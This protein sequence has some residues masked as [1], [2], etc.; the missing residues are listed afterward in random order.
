M[1]VRSGV[2]SFDLGQ[3]EHRYG[4]LGLVSSL[5]NMHLAFATLSTVI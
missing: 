5:E 1:R 2:L 3:V 4:W